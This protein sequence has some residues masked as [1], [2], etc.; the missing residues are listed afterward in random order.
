MWPFSRRPKDLSALPTITSD[1]HTWAI[2]EANY[3][4]SPLLVRINTSAKEWSGHSSLTIKV[5]FAVPLNSPNEGGMPDPEENHQLN[6]VEDAI[7][8]EVEAKAKGIL[9][10]VL[11]TGTMREFVFYVTEDADI[12]AIHKAIQNSVV[13]HEVQCMAVKDPK[14]ETYNQFGGV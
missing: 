4:Q 7:I 2:A 12:G 3:D 14:W 6:D 5:G 10:L 13:S 8:R 9:V 1:S 11:T